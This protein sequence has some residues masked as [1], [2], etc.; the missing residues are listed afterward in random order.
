MKQIKLVV[1]DADNTLWNGTVFY[2]DKENIKIKLGT[3]EAL[4]ELDKRG[5]KSTICSKNYYEDVDSM[6]KKFEIDE[7]FENLQIGWGLK[8]DAIRKLAGMYNINHD[9]ILFID[10]DPFQRAEV[11]SQMPSINAIGLD[12]PL[13]VLALDEVQPLNATAEDKKRV[14]LLKEQRN[15]EQA[16]KEHK[17]DFKEFLIHCSMAMTVRHIEEKDW[18]RVCQLINRTNELNATGNRY[19]LKELKESYEKNG[20][21]ILVVELTDKFGEYGLIAESIITKQ[22]YGW[23][24]KDLTVSCRTMGRG[25]GSALVVVILNYAKMQGIKKVRGMLVETESNWRVKPLY[26]KRGFDKLSVD[27]KKTFYEFDLDK[28]EIPEYHPWLKI[29][30]LLEKKIE[31]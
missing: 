27:G 5:I 2:K 12:D 11:Q 13:D 10:D 24:I 28:K 25:I 23:F 3:K 20:D 1:W 19:E 30:L 22:D 14:Q 6:L 29:N 7:Y 4:K 31:A 26:E 17:G 15:R 16:E 9:E 18:E 8:S 21:I